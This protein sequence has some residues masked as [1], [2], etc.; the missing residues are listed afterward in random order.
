LQTVLLDHPPERASGAYYLL[1]AYEF[2]KRA[3][4]HAVSERTVGS[5]SR[6]HV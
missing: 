4:A 2:I 3:R 6:A 5:L 1:L